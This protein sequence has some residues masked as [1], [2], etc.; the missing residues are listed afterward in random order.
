MLKRL[1]IGIFLLGTAC[2][3]GASASRPTL[4]LPAPTAPSPVPSS[5]AEQWNLTITS[6][7]FAG[8]DACSIYA[9]YV[10]E[11]DD[12]SMTMERSGDSIHVSMTLLDDPSA[13]IEFDG[14]VVS[15]VLIATARNSLQ[16]QVCGGSRVS[17]G[18]ERHVSGHFSEDGHRL[19]AEEVS[20]SQ[21][22]TGETLVFHS[23]WNATQK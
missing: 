15:G 1:T 17:L 21:L 6:R 18:A 9:K 2:G 3:C 19:T 10:G 20:S 4:I 16:G 5:A 22:S 12:W 8:P 7:D 13:H 11:S 23:D 14:R